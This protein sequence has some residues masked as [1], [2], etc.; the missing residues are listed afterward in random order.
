MNTAQKQRLMDRLNGRWVK[1]FGEWET[2][3]FAEMDVE[4]LKQAGYDARL[5]STT[6]PVKTPFGTITGKRWF[7]EKFQPEEAVDFRK[8]RWV[9]YKDPSNKSLDLDNLIPINMPKEE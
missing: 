3:S 2:K 1:A 5:N 7:A 9:K 8:G 4:S 6:K